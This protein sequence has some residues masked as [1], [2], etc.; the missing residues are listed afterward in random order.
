MTLGERIAKL[1]KELKMSQY[2]LAERLGMS[3]GKLANYEQGQRQPDYDTLK[4]IADF[5]GVSI[6]YLITGEDSAHH[7]SYVGP[8]PDENPLGIELNETELQTLREILNDPDVTLFFKDFAALGE[9][10]R[11]KVLAMIKA[12]RE[13]S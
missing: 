9:R 6:D 10:D 8:N 13:E 1:R 3:R 2:A 5:F 11:R 4:K 7:S 12:W